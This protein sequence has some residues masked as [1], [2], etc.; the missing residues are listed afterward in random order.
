MLGPH[1]RARVAAEPDGDGGDFPASQTPAREPRVDPRSHR[2]RHGAQLPL[3]RHH[4]ERRKRLR[5]VAVGGRLARLERTLAPLPMLLRPGRRVFAGEAQVG[6]LLQRQAGASFGALVEEVHV[7]LT[8]VVEVTHHLG[9]VAPQHR[10]VAAIVERP[11]HQI[12]NA[13]VHQS[14]PVSMLATVAPMAEGDSNAAR[15]ALGSYPQCTMQSWQ[16]GLPLFLP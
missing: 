7:R 4:D 3:Q 8:A 2:P 5:P 16:R 12:G 1:R 14:R 15:T 11:L 6:D 13:R 10:H 9:A